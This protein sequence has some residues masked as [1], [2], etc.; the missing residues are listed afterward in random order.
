MSA[1]PNFLWKI[2][3]TSEYFLTLPQKIRNLLVYVL[4]HVLASPA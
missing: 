2:S 1:P 3:F 4:L